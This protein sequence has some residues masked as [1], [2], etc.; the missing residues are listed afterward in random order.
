MEAQN[1]ASMYLLLIN[2][3][4]LVWEG[5][6]YQVEHDDGQLEL[7]VRNEIPK[8]RAVHAGRRIDMDSTYS[9]YSIY[10]CSITLGTGVYR[11]SSG[12]VAKK[13]SFPGAGAHGKLPRRCQLEY[14]SAAALA[15]PTPPAPN[16]KTIA[17][18]FD[19]C[20]ACLYIRYRYLF[21]LPN[22]IAD[23]TRSGRY[24]FSHGT[25]CKLLERSRSRAQPASAVIQ[26]PC[27]AM[28]RHAFEDTHSSSTLLHSVTIFQTERAVHV[29]HRNDSYRVAYGVGLK[30][31]DRRT[32][33]N[34]ARHR[35][36]VPLPVYKYSENFLPSSP[37]CTST[38]VSLARRA[39]H[40]RPVFKTSLCPQPG[41]SQRCCR[42]STPRPWAVPVGLRS[43]SMRRPLFRSP[44]QLCPAAAE[45]C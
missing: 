27:H 13:N 39:R 37:T 41:P 31:A 23:G 25:R 42:R 3:D 34:L 44:H 24:R 7:P 32:A 40:H 20:Y 16:R 30:K 14:C 11:I 19:K 10:Q 43:G 22:N 17:V 8:Y 9:M 15:F 21:Y 33:A 28:P 1:A 18:R 45:R 12:A 6:R 4:V 36:P 29:R 5:S 26:V 38:T 35:N 2:V